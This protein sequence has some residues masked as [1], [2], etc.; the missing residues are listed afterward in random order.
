[1]IF[2]VPPL[3]LNFKFQY[4]RNSYQMN[5]FHS[6][7]YFSIG[8]N[9]KKRKSSSWFVSATLSVLINEYFSFIQIFTT[10][11]INQRKWIVV[12][13]TEKNLSI[14][15]LV[16][17]NNKLNR[18]FHRSV[19]AKLPYSGFVSGLSQFSLLPQLPQ[20]WPSI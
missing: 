13:N 5:Y 12:L 14:F 4:L 20:K 7:S 19:Q 15:C 6:F 9:K 16:H 1:M 17:F 3:N 8:K 11:I 2:W 18:V 10:S